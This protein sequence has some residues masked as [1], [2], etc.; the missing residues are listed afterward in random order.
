MSDLS[1]MTPDHASK[2]RQTLREL[3]RDGRL[4]LDDAAVIRKDADGKLAVD[5]EI[6]RGVKLGAIGGGLLGLLLRARTTPGRCPTFGRHWPT[7][8]TRSPCGSWSRSESLSCTRTSRRVSGGC[9][10]TVGCL[11]MFARVGGCSTRGR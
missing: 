6:D 3:E 9:C 8:M 2:V 1:V 5:N 11:H 7:S 4:S 10:S